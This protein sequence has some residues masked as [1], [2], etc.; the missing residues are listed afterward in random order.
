M[1]FIREANLYLRFSAPAEF[2][3]YVSASRSM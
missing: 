1:A 2:G 3:R